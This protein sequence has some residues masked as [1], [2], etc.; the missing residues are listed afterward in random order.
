MCTPTQCEL[1][2][3]P[4]GT[5][6]TVVNQP[7]TDT[8]NDGNASTRN[9]TCNGAGLCLGTAF[10][11]TPTQ[12]EASSTPNGT[13][14]VIVNKA[15]TEACDDGNAATKDDTCNGSG[16]CLGTAFTC[17]PT[18]CQAS[19]TPNG[20]DC[21]VVNRP[22]T[23]TC[24]DQ[25]LT[26]RDDKCDGAG[27]CVGTPYTCTPTECQITSIPNGTDCTVT[28]VPGGDPCDD[29]DLCTGNERCDNQG[30]CAGGTAVTCAAGELCA[31]ATG[32]ASTH[33]AACE[34][35]AD[36]GEESACLA[37]DD[38]DRC[39]LACDD[40]EDCDLDQ[41]CRRHA[42]GSLRCFDQDGACAAPPENPEEGPEPGPEPVPDSAADDADV[43]T[44]DLADTGKTVVSGGDGCGAGG[45]GGG[46]AWLGMAL[47]LAGIALRRR[48]STRG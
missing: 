38:G 28:L 47:G 41:V 33:C 30:V 11:C 32:C 44:T 5:D 42:D 31:P 7:S 26:T 25:S 45:A 6:C 15:N 46:L 19:S 29:G 37:S 24:N 17:T 48:S 12:C 36:C 39:L 13:E 35:Q 4:N 43:T 3:T 34:E 22:S 20:T 8:C 16:A 2:S 9:D 27:A 23:A 14:C 10:T 18:Q 40:D 21:T 1:S